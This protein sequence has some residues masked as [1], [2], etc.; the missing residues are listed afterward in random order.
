[1]NDARFIIYPESKPTRLFKRKERTNIPPLTHNEPLHLI[2]IHFLSSSLSL[3]CLTTNIGRV[4][5]LMFALA[6]QTVAKAGQGAG[7]LEARHQRRP[8]PSYA[9]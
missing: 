9:R 4:L 2:M 6:G 5:A 8:R 7:A 3:S 1:M